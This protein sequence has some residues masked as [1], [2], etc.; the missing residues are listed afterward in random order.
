MR[1]LRLAIYSLLL[2]T[3]TIGISASSSASEGARHTA[4]RP[5]PIVHPPATAEAPHRATTETDPVTIPA[6][7]GTGYNIIS[8]WSGYYDAGT[9]YVK[10]VTP[11]RE[12]VSNMFSLRLR[13]YRYGTSLHPY[14][15]AISIRCDGYAYS[16]D[17][18][19]LYNGGCSVEGT[20]L[21]VELAFELRPNQTYRQIVVRI[22][23]PTT[24]WYFVDMSLDYTG[25]ISYTTSD[26]SWVINE[27]TPSL[28]SDMNTLMTG[29]FL[30]SGPVGIGTTAP[31]ALES[32][33]RLTVEASEAETVSATLPVP[34]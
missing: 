29:R 10:L 19:V 21:P 17:P 34:G 9:G 5:V 14:D 15:H 27:T 7:T 6:N 28:G 22:G 1:K 26:F 16:G 8:P 32:F 4:T 20:Q 3:I 23:T 31:T 30:A 13:I 18:G 33:S 12:N 2:G 11:I 24:N 25:W